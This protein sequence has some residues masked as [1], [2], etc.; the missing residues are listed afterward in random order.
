MIQFENLLRQSNLKV[1]PQRLII[2]DNLYKMGHMSID[3]LFQSIKSKIPSISLATIYKN[4]NAM[5]DVSLAQEVKIPNQKSK[6]EL[7]KKAHSHLVCSK[8][9]KV[10]DITLDLHGIVDEASSKSGYSINANSVV[11]SGICSECKNK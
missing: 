5:L 7:T 1:T 10:E 2:V 11:L 6:Y 3:E 9:G 8:C 4:I